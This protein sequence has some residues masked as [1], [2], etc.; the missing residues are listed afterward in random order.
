MGRGL[1][2]GGQKR[3]VVDI[4]ATVL[5]ALALTAGAAVSHRPGPAPSTSAQDEFAAASPSGPTSVSPSSLMPALGDGPSAAQSP[6]DDPDAEPS[7]S[8]TPPLPIGSLPKLHPVPTGTWTGINWIAI[9]GGHSPAVP[10][11][12]VDAPGPN[13]SLVGWSKG[14]VEFLWDPSKRTLNPRASSEGLHWRAGFRLDTSAWAGDFRNYDSGNVDDDLFP[15]AHDACT[16]FVVNFQEGPT[17]LLVTGHVECTRGCGGDFYTGDATWTSTD[18]LAWT[19]LD[20]KSIFGASGVGPISGGASGFVALGS[21]AGRPVVWLSSDGRTWHQGS[22]PAASL[23]EGSSVDDP[24]AMAGGYVLPGVLPVRMGHQRSTP[25]TCTPGGYEDLSLYQ[26][27][28]WWSAD[29]TT[30]SRDAFSVITAYQAY[31]SVVRIDDHTVV[32][33]ETTESGDTEWVSSDGKTWVRLTGAPICWT[34]PG[35]ENAVR[36]V[37]ASRDRGIVTRCDSYGSERPVSVFDS[38]L[39]FVTLKQTGNVPWPDEWQIALGPT[40]LLVTADGSRFWIGVPTGG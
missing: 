6:T 5:V 34:F 15:N 9:P 37:V 26:G 30:W 22:L 29:G 17:T 20:A 19:F 13:A 18:S 40:G 25:G 11:A 3:R 16:F 14:Y 2:L 27:A 12:D 33:I 35:N 8:P 39:K 36:N 31:M 28:L 32:A 23:E 38:K 7:S 24:V 4:A 21:S 1:S 10:V